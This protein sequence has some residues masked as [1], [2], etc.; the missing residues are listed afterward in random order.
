[1][2]K[3]SVT[4]SLQDW[5]VKDAS[6]YLRNEQLNLPISVIYV[7]VIAPNATMVVYRFLFGSIH[8]I[9]FLDCRF[10]TLGKF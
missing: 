10:A 4:F 3:I 1:M 8:P 9:A 2:I 6:C 5:V 7:S